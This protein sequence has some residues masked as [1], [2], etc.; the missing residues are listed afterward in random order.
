MRNIPLP[1]LRE[2]LYGNPAMTDLLEVYITRKAN[3]DLRFALSDQDVVWRGRK[4]KAAGFKKSFRTRHSITDSLGELTI[5]LPDI[6]REIAAIIEST[7]IAGTMVLIRSVMLNRLSVGDSFEFYRGKIQ[8]PVVLQGTTVVLTLVPECADPDDV[9]VLPGR[10]S[11]HDCDFTYGQLGTCGLDLTQFTY[12]GTVGAASTILTIQDNG[13]DAAAIE[14]LTTANG[15]DGNGDAR[16]SPLPA[17]VICDSGVNVGQSRP[18]A[19]LNPCR[20]ELRRPFYATPAV[21]D[22]FRLQ[23]RCPHTA[24]ACAGFDNSNNFGGFANSEKAPRNLMRE[25]LT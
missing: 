3:P 9:I 16:M 8:A 18:V 2:V 22:A 10:S 11:G 13:L 12:S 15:V 20:I 21:G 17:V 23:R 6:S 24:D 7:D 4:Y 1:I 5:I 25:L 14:A 19:S